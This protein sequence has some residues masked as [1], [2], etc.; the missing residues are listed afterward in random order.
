[1]AL[2][3]GSEG[4]GLQ[5]ATLAA[6]DRR[7]RI[8]LAPDVDSLNLAVAAAIAMHHVSPLADR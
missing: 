8:P 5:P 3:V 4:P 2:L 1:M 6:A 7:V